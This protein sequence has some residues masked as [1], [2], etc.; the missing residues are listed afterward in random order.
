MS[1]LRIRKVKNIVFKTLV[2]TFALLSCVP[3]VLILYTIVKEG[4]TSVNL[5][6]LFNLPK[7]VGEMGGGF[8]MHL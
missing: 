1:N 8:L 2:F 6:F 5:N 4:V 3:L 7:P